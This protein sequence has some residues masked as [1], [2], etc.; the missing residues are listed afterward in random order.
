[1]GG[2]GQRKH[3]ALTCLTGRSWGVLRVAGCAGRGGDL[4]GV[5]ADEALELRSCVFLG[6]DEVLDEVDSG[7]GEQRVCVIAA[8]MGVGLLGEQAAQ[9]F[10]R[11]LVVGGLVEAG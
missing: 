6:V 2:E 4:G 11:P 1:V 8:R 10:V 9:Q 3:L 7:E 5:F